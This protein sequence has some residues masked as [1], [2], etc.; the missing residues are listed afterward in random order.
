MSI[1]ALL[2]S[3]TQFSFDRH[4][5]KI[6]ALDEIIGLLKAIYAF[7][8]SSTIR[9]NAFILGLEVNFPVFVVDILSK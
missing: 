3:Y 6:E 7:Q 5:K 9:H 8:R 1:Y 4:S 2:S